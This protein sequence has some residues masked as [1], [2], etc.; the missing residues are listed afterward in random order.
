MLSLSIEFYQ[1]QQYG[2]ECD[3]NR[4]D[5]ILS[6]CEMRQKAMQEHIFEGF[7][8]NWWT[9]QSCIWFGQNSSPHTIDGFHS[10]IE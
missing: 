9:F 6:Y 7:E 4:F 2:F 10:K 8:N 5:L 3:F 1:T